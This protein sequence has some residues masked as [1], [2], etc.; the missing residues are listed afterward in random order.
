MFSWSP[1]WA[2]DGVQLNYTVI[3]NNT[4]TGMMRSYTT[5]NTS[6]TV[7]VG[8]DGGCGEYVWSVSAVN[9]AGISVPTNQTFRT[10]I[11]DSG[12]YQSLHSS[13]V[14]YN[15]IVTNMFR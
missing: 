9:P 6:I 1:P 13:L 12:V 2:P 10:T 7:N 5:S 3:V 15:Y 14:Y 4:V 8:E 11:P